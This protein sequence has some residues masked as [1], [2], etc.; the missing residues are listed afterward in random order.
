[1]KKTSIST[2]DVVLK[3]GHM[4]MVLNND[5]WELQNTRIKDIKLRKKWDLRL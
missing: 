5:I 2:A 4:R 3:A 1:M